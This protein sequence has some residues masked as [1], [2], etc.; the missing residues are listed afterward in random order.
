M[1][2][3]RVLLSGCMPQK[4]VA[5]K[6]S[7]AHDHPRAH[8][9]TCDIPAHIA[10]APP[11]HSECVCAFNCCVLGLRGGPHNV[12]LTYAVCSVTVGSNQSSCP[13]TRSHP[14]VTPAFC[15]GWV[16]ELPR[17]TCAM[18]FDAD[19]LSLPSESEGEHPSPPSPPS[20]TAV[21]P[22]PS[23]CGG[24]A[25][26]SHAAAIFVTP[27]RVG[28]IGPNC[29]D[30]ADHMRAALAGWQPRVGLQLRP[31][32]VDSACS[33]LCTEEYA[34][35]RLGLLRYEHRCA[36]DPKPSVV[37]FSVAEG[38]TQHH[39]MHLTD[40]LQDYAECRTHGRRC[41]TVGNPCYPRADIFVAGISCRP[42]STLRPGR[43]APD[44]VEGHGDAG[45][46]NECLQHF[47]K[48]KPHAF[49][50]E[51]V[52][53]WD[54]RAASGSEETWLQRHLAALAG[55][56]S[57]GVRVFRMDIGAW[58]EASRLRLY[59][60]GIRH[61][62]SNASSHAATEETLDRIEAL[63]RHALQLRRQAPPEKIY[64]LLIRPGQPLFLDKIR[65][66]SQMADAPDCPRPVGPQFRERT[67]VFSLACVLVLEST[68]STVVVS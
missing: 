61:H 52:P 49:I 43:F 20:P 60:V 7:H 16:G 21:R 32:L 62:A 42:F 50:L 55:L 22:H 51:N 36:A 63:V 10:L 5:I 57:Y 3:R 47:E 6:C 65:R 56:G 59:M 48:N 12:G 38:V 17:Q 23:A 66:Q 19:A 11:R 37:A 64:D 68:C 44:S 45:L 1:G 18:K 2:N 15:G 41:A 34:L 25:A 9:F 39:F 13:L 24:A 33:G 26:S 14:D 53:G 28:P 40:L 31:L 54:M 46:F 8:G 29:T 27:T 67:P 30:W 35:R 4:S 58:V